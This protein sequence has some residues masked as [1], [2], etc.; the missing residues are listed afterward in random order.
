MDNKKFLYKI[1]NLIFRYPNKTVPALDNISL[2][3]KSGDFITIAGNCGSGKTTLLKMLKPELTPKGQLSG[4]VEFGDEIKDSLSIGYVSQ[5]PDNQIVTD[6]VWH[7]LSFGLE[8][9]GLKNYEIRNK[10]AETASFF[11]IQNWFE[12]D[13]NALS[14]GQKQILCLA[15]VMAMGVSVIILDEPTSQLDPIAASEFINV[16]KKINIE[17]GTT[18][19]IADHSTKELIDSSTKL[20]VM[21]EGSIIKE[22]KPPNI[23]IN[24]IYETISFMPCP[25]RVYA[26]LSKL[27]L[28]KGDS[29]EKRC[30]LNIKEGRD[31]IKNVNDNYSGKGN[32]PNRLQKTFDETI[33]SCK[34]VFYSYDKSGENVLKGTSLSVNKGE[35]FTILGGN[36][37]GK[38]TLFNVLSGNYKGYQGKINNKAKKTVF[39]NQDPMAMFIKDTVW[40]ETIGIAKDENAAREIL[41]FFD[42]LKYKDTH[43]YD[44]SG[45]EKQKLALAL[46]LLCNPDILLLDEPVKGM[47]NDIKNETG[48]KLRELADSGITILIITHDLDFAAR[49]SNKCAMM[50]NGEITSVGTPFEFFENNNFYTTDAIRMS[51]GIIKNILLPEDIVEYFNDSGKK[52]D[53]DDKTIKPS[54]PINVED[55]KKTEILEKRNI[56]KKEVLLSVLTIILVI[57]TIL[58]GYFKLN[59]EKY[60]FISLLVM[61]EIMAPFYIIFEKHNYSIRW[62]V[63]IAVL[64][65]MA[66]AGRAVFYMFPEFKPVAALVIIAGYCLGAETGFMVGSLTML[67]SNMLFSQ[68]PW[69]PWQMLAMGLIGFFSCFLFYQR[70]YKLRIYVEVI[71]GFLAVF[72]LYGGIMNVSAAFLSHSTINMPT[73]ISFVATGLPLDLIH[74][75]ATVVFLLLLAKPLE[76]KI[77]RIVVKYK[78]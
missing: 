33:I 66:V 31:F 24:D 26:G 20:I 16:L 25:V 3:I 27:G 78:L 34:D 74:G 1:E 56:S 17:L 9:L 49:Y 53:I 67:V 23:S 43:P 7:E 15:S 28:N 10:V 50:F 37:T 65:A 4:S 11:G 21:D 29:N 73:I 58:F 76:E 59:D 8:S 75:L 5:N 62:L 14:G 47:D 13:V 19:I 45:G 41:K 61:I 22:I 18:V 57:S 32:F 52:L 69:T 44:L 36:G 70:N 12:K 55:I 71:Y 2:E 39:L 46:V 38:T 72:I 35:I 51:K 42:L 64:T 54:K 60:L 6:K 40:E 30:P 77:E 68:G 63:L 48:N